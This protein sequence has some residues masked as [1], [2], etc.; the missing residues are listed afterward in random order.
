MAHTAQS[1]SSASLL[2]AVKQARNIELPDTEWPGSPLPDIL[3]LAFLIA[4]QHPRESDALQEVLDRCTTAVDFG[5]L[6]LSAEKA[7]TDGDVAEVAFFVTAH[8][9]AL[10]YQDRHAA[11]LA[12][13]TS[14]PAAR[15]G[16][17]LAEKIFAAHD[18]SR[19]GQ[20]Q[21]GD[22]IRLDVDWVIAS[23]LSW[24]GMSKTYDAMGKPGIFRND[25]LWIAGDHVVDPRV[26]QVPKIKALVES[27]EKA[28]QVFKLTEY[29]GM[30]YT[31]MHTEFCRERAQPGMLIIG[32]DSHTCSA[33]SVSSLAIGLGVADVTLPLITG[34]TWIKV[35]ETVEIRFIN[36]PKPGLGGKDVILY[37]LKELK[38]NT[39]AADRVVE[40]TGPGMQ[41][42]SCDAR[43][44][45]C[46]MT[47]EFGGVTGICVPDAIT[48]DFINRRKQ[49]KH[50]R[51]ALYYRP[52]DDAQYAETYIIDLD[53]VEPFVARYPSPDDVVPIS[54]LQDT[55]LDGCFIGACTT[56]REDLVLA[57]LVLEAGL[58]RG[59][60]PVGHGKRKVVPG[61]RPIMHELEELGLADIYRS[62]GFVI[63]VPGCSYCV[64]MSADKASPGEVWISS[65]NRNFENR[66]GPGSIGHVT[67]AVTVASSS[68][69]M[70]IQDPSSLLEEIDTVRLYS[71]LG[72]GASKAREVQYV[73]PPAV[74]ETTAQVSG[75]E[76]SELQSTVSKSHRIMGKV[77]TLGD[78]ID[79]D[80]LAP[81]EALTTARTAEEFGSYCL[82]HTHPEFRARVKEG[83][84]IVVA[85]RG[86]GVGSSREN[87]VTALQGA[88]VQCV[89]AR[90]FAF[91]YARNQPNL[92]LLGIVMEHDEFYTLA[93][94]GCDI[95]IDV[96]ARLVR[97]QE[98]EFGF[99]LAPLEV[100]LWEQ[101]GIGAAFQQWGKGVLAAMTGT[102]ATGK[103]LEGQ[104]ESELAW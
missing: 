100:R 14:R 13:F 48:A 98:R 29:Q 74:Q 41:H 63:G 54:E 83:L 78:F 76:N 99:K 47:T 77:Q 89:I 58:K 1:Y 10:N 12:A 8:L 9:E 15:R 24:H 21:P 69:D 18:V 19:K 104:T 86:F 11:K 36:K 5:G 51:D 25:R 39:V 101:G 91:I 40:Y 44:A 60:K 20:V 97:V 64:G 93:T 38:R 90:S 6:G 28:R 88:G 17:T 37:I 22:V 26:M 53:K 81:S 62:A 49:L 30:N 33:G 102:K 2:D 65:Q 34:E 23:E 95:E 94:N 73:E 85:G 68:F 42:L 57:A 56:A 3:K 92:G 50:K 31:I 55:A 80:A 103:G 66:M 72:R 7:L 87:A 16:M 32:S 71:I 52:D 46:N 96:D 79:T 84:N 27:S 67:T 4:K 70:K 43:F 75:T 35:P 61:S 82:Y 59:M 45:I